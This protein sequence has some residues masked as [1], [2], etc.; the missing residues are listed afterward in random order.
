MMFKKVFSFVFCC[1]STAIFFNVSAQDFKLSS[2]PSQYQKP[3]KNALKAA[4]MNRTELEKVLANLPKEMREGAAFLIAYMPKND[5]TTIKSILSI[6]LK[7]LTRQDQ[8]F[9]GQR[10]FQIQFF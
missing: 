10:K 5:L 8:R 6:I 1:L 3:V 9:P 2:L 4:G 7:R